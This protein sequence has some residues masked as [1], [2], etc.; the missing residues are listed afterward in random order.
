MTLNN[1]SDIFGVIQHDPV[2]THKANIKEIITNILTNKEYNLDWTN[3][4]YEFY[5]EPIKT[6]D[7]KQNTV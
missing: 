2:N 7:I 5:N 3:L 6:I 4:V 1:L